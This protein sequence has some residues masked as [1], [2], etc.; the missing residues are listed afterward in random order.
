MR[1]SIKHEIAL[2]PFNQPADLWS[3]WTDIQT[4]KRELGSHKSQLASNKVEQS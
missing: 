4:D 2:D 1:M 3:S